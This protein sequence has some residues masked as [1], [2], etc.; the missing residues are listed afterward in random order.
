MTSRFELYKDTTTGNY[1]FVL[2]AG[3]GEPVAESQVYRSVAD[4]RAGMVAVQRA[5][6][7]ASIPDSD[8][9]V[10]VQSGNYIHMHYLKAPH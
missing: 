9:A 2:K 8:D 3:N 1:W 7:A 4:A 5:A 10:K 6:E